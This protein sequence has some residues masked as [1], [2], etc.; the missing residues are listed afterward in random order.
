M[1]SRIEPI[2]GAFDRVPLA[3]TVPLKSPLSLYV[4]PSNA[5][6]FRCT[7]CAHSMKKDELREVYGIERTIL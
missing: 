5:C 7:Y 1:P 4:F 3:E 6:N 2:A